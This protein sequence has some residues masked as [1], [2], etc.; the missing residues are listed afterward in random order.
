MIIKKEAG[1]V[2]GDVVYQ[3][4]MESETGL[5]VSFYTYGGIIQSLIVKDRQGVARDVELG[6]DTLE[7]YVKAAC[8]YGAPVGRYANRIRGAKFTID[9]KEY[10]LTANENGN[11]LHGGKG[12]TFRVWQVVKEEDGDEPSVTL[13][14]ESPDGDDG[15]PGNL[16]MEMTYTLTKDNGLKIEYRGT[17]DQ[18]TPVNMTNH[19]FFN[20]SGEGDT[21]LDHV[22]WLDADC[23]TVADE[24]LLP[25]GELAQVKGTP[26]DFTSPK[27]VGQEIDADEPA[28]KNNSGYDLNYVINGW[29]GTVKRIASLSSPKTGIQMDVY[30]DKPGVQLFTF[31]ING[32]MPGKGGRDYP[33][34]SAVCLE[35]QFFPDTPNHPEFPGGFAAPGEMYHYTTEYRFHL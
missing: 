4:T 13:R 7:E 3:Y 11:T 23:Y 21:A 31:N 19:S 29:N 16:T 5:K 12:L 22:L 24:A 20:L 27:A 6:L 17:T 15:F 1:K 33:A 35:T 8:Y 28:L 18:K 2:Q 34:H 9:G 26:F 25:T 32:T 14:V 30:T 10:R